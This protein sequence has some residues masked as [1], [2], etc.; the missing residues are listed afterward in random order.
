MSDCREVILG[1]AA[2]W[3]FESWMQDY[4]L[5]SLV[6]QYVDFERGTFSTSVPSD[7]P[8]EAAQ[9]F[10]TGLWS[11]SRLYDC[12]IRKIITD[13]VWKD[14]RDSRECLRVFEESPSATRIYYVLSN[15]MPAPITARILY[16]CLAQ[17]PPMI[18]VFTTVRAGDIGRHMTTD[19]LAAM[20]RGV[21]A[22]MIGA[23]DGEG[24]VTWRPRGGASS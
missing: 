17:L 9:C 4:H 24:F 7:V 1:V 3:W 12:S 11:Q 2:R 5:P 22:L 13:S 19:T 10:E 18:G 20:A 6:S 21:Q 15:S 23:Y 14:L 16:D 8:D